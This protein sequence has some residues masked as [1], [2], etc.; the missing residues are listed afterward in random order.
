MGN[1]ETGQTVNQTVNVQDDLDL[2]CQHIIGLFLS[3]DR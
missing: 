2:H 3:V 1:E